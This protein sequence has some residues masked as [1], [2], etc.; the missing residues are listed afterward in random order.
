MRFVLILTL[1]AL[2]SIP[3]AFAA[4]PDKILDTQE[5]TALATKAEQA[6]PKDRCYLYAEL[7]SA[8]TQLASQQL[9]AGK[10]S[11]A[12]ESLEGGSGIYGEDTPR[13]DG[14]FQKTERCSD[15]DAAHSISAERIDDECLSQ[16]RA[17]VS[18]DFKTVGSGSVAN[19][20]G[21]F[22]EIE[23]HTPL[24]LQLMNRTGA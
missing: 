17:Y 14:Q 12:S 15:H 7:V 16:R 18:V 6:T 2:S 3:A 23:R 19:D 9:N 8:M 22:P 13:S 24:T 4:N 11:D 1:A 20:A 10:S 5:L 21:S